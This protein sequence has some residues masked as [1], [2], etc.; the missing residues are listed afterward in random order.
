VTSDSAAIGRIFREES[1]RS[2]AALTGMFGDVDLA[3][4]A[5]QEAFAVALHR[6]PDDGIPPNPGAWIT[7]TARNRAVDR[8]RRDTRGTELIKAAA[9]AS[10][11]GWNGDPAMEGKPVPDDR[12]RLIFTCCHPSLAPQSQ[13]ELTLRLLC[14]LSTA[15]VARAFLTAEPTMAKRLVRTKHKIK[16]ANIPYRIPEE[17]ELPDRLKTVLIAI[18]L[19]YT[20]GQGKPQSETDLCSES[21]RLGRMLRHLMPDEPEIAGLLALMLLTESRRGTRTDELGALV[22]LRDQNRAAW[23]RALIEEGHG[24]VRWCLRRNQPGPFQL[25]AAIAAVHADA[26]SFADT[27]WPQIL[28]L[29]DQLKILAPTP[30]V[31]LNRAVAL[32]EVRGP[33]AGLREIDTLPL[34]DYYPFHAARAE[35]LLRQGHRDEAACA[36]RRAAELAPAGPERDFLRDQAERA[37]GSR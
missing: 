15:E 3:E 7:T 6:W 18:Y 28:T 14:G 13:V 17:H 31:A 10:P 21:I 25:Q 20:T 37:P 4:D 35:F 23:N 32:G 19:M 33:A 22:L 8:L 9:Q 29:Y 16:A 36:F 34:S 1:G 30:V 2:V 26:A 27:D 24:L 11:P 5:V 12:L